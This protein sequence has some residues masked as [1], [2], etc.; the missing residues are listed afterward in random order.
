MNE[1]WVHLYNHLL[2]MYFRAINDNVKK[3]IF[4]DHKQNDS[5]DVSK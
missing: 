3:T 5:I 1:F 4:D 2:S